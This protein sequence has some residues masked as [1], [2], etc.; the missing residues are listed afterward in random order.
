MKAGWSARRV[1]RPLGRSDCVVRRCLDQW[2]QEMSFTRRPGSGRLR[3]INASVWS[4]A[5]LEETGQQRNGT[6]SSL[7]TNTD[8]ISAND[9][10]VLVWRP[11]GERPNPAFALQ[12][13]TS[14]T[15]SVMVWGAIV[16]NTRSPLVL[17][18]GTM[19]AQRY[20]QDILQLHVLP[21]LPEAIFQQDNARPHT[22][23][24]S[25]DCLRT[26]TILP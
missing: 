12:R 23:R 3:Q 13:H 18:R 11:R 15:A 17:T 5:T 14:P 21:R 9:N 6:R 24:V 1:A 10:R 4:G 2:I 22:A 19:T 25:Q 7:V 26:V 8:L 16:Y 20:V